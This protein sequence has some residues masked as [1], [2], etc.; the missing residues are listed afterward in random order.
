M[1]GSE[2]PL[3]SASAL[4]GLIESREASPVE[5]VEAYLQR[6]DDLDFKFNSFITV[7]RERGSGRGEAG[8]AGNSGR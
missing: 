1:V 8:R 2:L 6:I 5:V 4:A 3:H 7:L